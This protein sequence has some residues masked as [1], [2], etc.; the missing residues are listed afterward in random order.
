MEEKF[1]NFDET[2]NEHNVD[3]MSI[4]EIMNE[5]DKLD[6]E[7]ASQFNQLPTFSD[8]VGDRNTYVKTRDEFFESR[9][10]EHLI[11]KLNDDELENELPTAVSYTEAEVGSVL[12]RDHILDDTLFDVMSRI[13]N[14]GV[15]YSEISHYYW[16]IRGKV[17]VR[18]A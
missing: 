15:I 13:G 5:L 16:Q 10:I 4:A 12:T 6:R 14:K 8:Y 3:D 18:I 17:L 9:K 1:M 2:K 11:D 7:R